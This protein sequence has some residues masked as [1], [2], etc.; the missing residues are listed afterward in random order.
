MLS[1]K[2]NEALS[3]SLDSAQAPISIIK[4]DVLSDNDFDSNAINSCI[5]SL[6]GPPASNF[7][8]KLLNYNSMYDNLNKSSQFKNRQSPYSEINELNKFEVWEQNKFEQQLGKTG[9]LWVQVAK[10]EFQVFKNRILGKKPF[11]LD[12]NRELINYF[13]L[14]YT[15][16]NLDLYSLL[17]QELVGS[18]Y[19]RYYLKTFQLPKNLPKEMAPFYSKAILHKIDTENHRLK[20]SKSQLSYFEILKQ[21]KFDIKSFYGQTKHDFRIAQSEIP[22]ELQ[23]LIWHPSFEIILQKLDQKVQLSTTEEQ[24]FYKSVM[25]LTVYIDSRSI[26]DEDS[27]EFLKFING[28]LDK[29]INNNVDDS[30]FD[31]PS[32]V[33]LDFF[34]DRYVFNTKVNFAN[35]TRVAPSSFRVKKFKQY[36]NEI[37]AKSK[38]VVSELFRDA[39][40]SDKTEIYKKIDSIKYNYPNTSDELASYLQ[41]GIDYEMDD[42]QLR[43]SNVNNNKFG[44][45]EMVMRYFLS[46]DAVDQLVFYYYLISAHDFDFKNLT[47][48]TNEIRISDYASGFLNEIS[49]SN[50]S[51]SQFDYGL[52]FLAHEVGHVVSFVLSEQYENSTLKKRTNQLMNCISKRNP[53]QSEIVAFSPS[54]KS[55]YVEEDWADYFQSKV[56]TKIIQNKS[57]SI[58]NNVKA[59]ALVSN[60]ENEYFNNLIQANP[61]DV[62]SS[63]FIRL[64]LESNDRKV[65]TKACSVF[66]DKIKQ[67]NRNLNCD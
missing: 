62:H 64:L 51:L 18:N 46:A 44:D 56:M 33:L 2:S 67:L 26:S 5:E 34:D 66:N 15:I 3:T 38:E 39:S 14:K 24:T 63:D 27:D 25:N 12:N 52:G 45:F 20:Y 61:G 31:A 53:L 23:H 32:S 16:K 19:G 37:A 13:A 40:Q 9:E 7:S 10:K 57:I 58:A 43:L 60:T 35:S 54:N 47:K 6:C 65:T 42:L 21:S 50:Y 22:V 1:A 59:C 41:A 17:I 28:K 30:E 4:Q 36:S 11:V 55:M 48:E 8:S 29:I 49:I